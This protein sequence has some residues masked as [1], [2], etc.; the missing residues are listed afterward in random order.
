MTKPSVNVPPVSM[1]RVKRRSPALGAFVEAG[2]LGVETG[3]GLRGSYSPDDAAALTRR[4]ATTL[5]ALARLRAGSAPDDA[6]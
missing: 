1:L 3:R 6:G 5:L 2:D 4:R